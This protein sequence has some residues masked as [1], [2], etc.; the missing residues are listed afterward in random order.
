VADSGTIA[1]GGCGV[2]TPFAAGIGNAVLQAEAA[3]LC[4]GGDS[5]W[6]V[7]DDFL[8]RYDSFPAELKRERGAWITAGALSH[9]CEDAAV[10]P[11]DFPPERI[12][13]V[14][15]SA[16]AGQIGMISFAEEV[17]AQSARFVSPIHFP[18]TVGNYIA[19]ALSRAF[20]IQGPNLTISNGAA[21][22]LLA[23]SAACDLLVDGAADIALAGGTEVLSDVLVRSLGG[24]EFGDTN[25]G[26]WSEGACIYV[27]RPAGASDVPA[28]AIIREWATAGPRSAPAEEGSV[29]H[30]V[31]KSLA[32]E[33]AMRL[34]AAV[35]ISDAPKQRRLSQ[36]GDDGAVTGLVVERVESV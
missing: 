21:S 31:G 30:V 4:S 35:Y 13:L 24:S 6:A 14:V 12:A 36:L 3:T 20:N 25:A 10:K 1:V 2:V 28:R 32:A 9:A 7:P 8:Q 16:L 34:G 15:G 23:I 18:Q 19:G 29:A 22:G 17:R 11:A 33:S 26:V 5:Y 27:L